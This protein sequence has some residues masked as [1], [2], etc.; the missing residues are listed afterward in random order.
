MLV[1]KQ[2]IWGELQNHFAQIK[3]KHLRDLFQEDPDRAKKFS[4]E[5]EDIFLDYSKNRIT[6]ETLD[7]LLKLAEEVNLKQAILDMFSGKR[8]NTTEDRPVLHIAL[9]NETSLLLRNRSNK[10]ILVDGKD[11]MPKIN[12]VL[13]KMRDFAKKI[14]RGEW[15][16]YSGMPI[17][18]IINIGIGGSDLGSKMTYEALRSYT[19]RNLKVRFISNIDA[20]DFVEKTIDLNPEETLFI[21]SSK[22]FT[23]I[24]T[25][26]NAKTAKK[27]ILGNNPNTEDIAKHFVAVSTNLEEVTKFGINPENMFEMWDWVGGRFSLCSAIGL[28]VMVGIGP[29]NFDELLNGFHKIDEHLFQTE[30]KRNIPVLM[31]LLGVWYN[32]FFKTQ[33]QAILPYEEYLHYLP[34]HL[35][36]VEMESNGK[37]VTLSGERVNYQTGAVVWGESGTNGQHAFYQLIHHG[38]ILVPTDFIGFI[39]SNNQ[40]GNHQI[41]LV[42]NLIAQTEALAFGKT[43]EELKAE[44]VSKELLPFKKFE[45]NKPSTTIVFSKLTPFTLGQLIALYEHKVFVQ[46][47]IWGINSFDQ[48]GVEL[49]K[50]LAKKVFTELE[51]P[52]VQLN[53]D[54]STN[55]LIEKFRK[56]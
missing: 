3:D 16:G 21:V 41:Q 18:N 27:W 43:E 48:W 50:V 33:T 47:V 54:S 1:T 22:S 44:G 49:G 6:S 23:T 8:I 11:V 52:S 7:L 32:D 17:K 38:T 13:D 12:K 34:L 45:G 56:A 15:R 5:T 30:F 46:G 10:P 19:D 2:K 42:A 40:I 9:R 37:S 24:E 51:N 25:M 35:Q 29:D 39:N 28:P 31:G 36:Q 14:R 26:T 4:I 55:Q 53:H 20:T